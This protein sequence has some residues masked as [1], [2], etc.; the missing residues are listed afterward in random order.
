VVVGLCLLLA[1]SL[2]CGSD[3]AGPSTPSAPSPAVPAP[4]SPENAAPAVD[5]RFDGAISC[6]PHG[7]FSCWLPV[8]ATASDPDGDSLTYTWSGCATGT[9]AAAVCTVKDPG[10]V[11]ATVTVDDGHGHAVSAAVSGRGDPGPDAVP[12]VRILFPGGDR[13]TPEPHAPCSLEVVA[14]AVDANDDALTYRWS[15]CAS[16]DGARRT[17][18][19][20]A[21][22]PVSV[23]VVV[24]DG[25]GQTAYASATAIG[26]GVNGPPDVQIGYVVV[27]ALAPAEIDILGNVIDPDD[28]LLCGR[29]YCGAASTFGACGP[30]SPVFE[31]TCLAGLEV[32][33]NR[34]APTG[35]CTITIEVKDRWGTV[36]RPTITIDVETLKILSHTLD[37]A[38]RVPD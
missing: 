10:P 35:T 18:V 3:A 38:S 1:T 4:P 37:S 19:V 16:G 13:C 15:G 2:A 12:T 9:G 17:C 29:E 24:E 32:R 36:G 6:T 26:E 14:Q 30:A 22:G 27:P 5:V 31:C 34:A 28:G 21:P 11:T 20:T 33:L 7:S 8:S 25:R 23:S